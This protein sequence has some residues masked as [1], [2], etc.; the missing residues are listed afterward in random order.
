MSKARVKNVS[1]KIFY[2]CDIVYVLCIFATHLQAAQNI[3]TEI[4]TE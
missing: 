4:V 3:Q 1:N 2:H